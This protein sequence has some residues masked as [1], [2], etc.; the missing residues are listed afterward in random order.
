[1]RRTPALI[2]GGGPAGSAA[3]I[4]L[5]RG[6][7]RPVVLERHAAADAICGG[8]VSWRTLERLATLGVDPATLGGDPIDT[9][10]LFAGRHRRTAPL[11]G[12]GMGVS[13]RRLDGLLRDAAVR[14]GA[15][16]ETGV[17]VRTLENGVARLADGGDM[18][19]D[20]IFLATGK[21]DLRGS[22][23]PA[24]ARGEDPTLGLRVRLSPSAAN[25]AAM[26]GRVE[27]H[28]FDRGYV[29]L[30][31]QEDGSANLCL[32]V[33]R[34]RLN[35]AGSPAA[36]LAELA[37]E[38]PVLA[39]RLADLAADPPVDAIANVPYGWRAR[40]TE[41]G[42]YRLGDQAGVIPS[43][44]GEGMGIAIASGIGAGQARLRGEGAP[45]WQARFARRIAAPI[46]IAGAARRLAESRRAAR[47]LPVIP[48]SLVG[49]VAQ[50]TRVGQRP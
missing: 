47:F 16:V 30:V 18:A 5:A 45:D 26:A 22:A 4:T 49:W 23:R 19:G 13:R 24:G 48:T 21:H 12:G 37:H 38:A 29:G 9:V 39:E 6:G 1:M 25:R 31:L 44:A 2:V 40:T 32:A 34:S 10:A 27:L 14:A 17:M 8:F 20:A 33:H 46:A 43:L 7:V 41:H 11:P 15:A 36:L 28:L 42:L 3:A 35:E 50:V